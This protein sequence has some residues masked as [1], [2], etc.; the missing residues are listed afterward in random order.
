MVQNNV[1]MI[2]FEPTCNHLLFLLLIRERR[3]IPIFEQHN[4]IEPS[5]SAWQADIL[6]VIRMLQFCPGEGSRTHT[7][8]HMILSHACL[9][10][11]SHPEFILMG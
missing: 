2:G 6:T 7:L 1:G 9:P 4:G 8:S 3:Y 5:S 10:V 11:P